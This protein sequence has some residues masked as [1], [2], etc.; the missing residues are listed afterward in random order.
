MFQ[1]NCPC[2]GSEKVQQFPEPEIS[3]SHHQPNN[4]PSP[5]MKDVMQYVVNYASLGISTVKIMRGRRPVVYVV[6]AVAGGIVGC[7]VCFLNY[8]QAFNTEL[9]E[10]PNPQTLYQCGQCGHHFSCAFHP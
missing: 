1:I 6:G 5:P 10:S 4:F 7:A 8:A 2:C 3:Q 9:S